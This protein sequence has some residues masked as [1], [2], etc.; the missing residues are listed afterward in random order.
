MQEDL[1]TNGIATLGRKHAVDL[2]YILWRRTSTVNAVALR[3]H[4]VC[5]QKRVYQHTTMKPQDHWIDANQ[6]KLNDQ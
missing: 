6:G 2:R 3:Q 5:L 1:S 4:S